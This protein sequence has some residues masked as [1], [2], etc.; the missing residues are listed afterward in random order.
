MFVLL[1]DCHV[2]IANIPGWYAVRHSIDAMVYAN[3]YKWLVVI[4]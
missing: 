4:E 3:L 1:R 2:C